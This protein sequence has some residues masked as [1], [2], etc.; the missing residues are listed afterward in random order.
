M[1]TTLTAAHVSHLAGGTLNLPG[2]AADL[3]AK[4]KVLTHL[5]ATVTLTA[6]PPNVKCKVVMSDI[7]ADLVK[8]LC[9]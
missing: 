3:K 8:V 9:K 5:D 1:E 6:A 7:T 4:I 2:S